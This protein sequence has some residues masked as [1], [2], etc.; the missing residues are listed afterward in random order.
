ME[1][2][3]T[4]EVRR[5]WKEKGNATAFWN[6]CAW[7]QE[8]DD[9]ADVLKGSAPEHIEKLIQDSVSETNEEFSE[10]KD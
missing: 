6:D 10:L 8:E 7:V 2:K 5:P 3:Y 4:Y 9:E 1:Q